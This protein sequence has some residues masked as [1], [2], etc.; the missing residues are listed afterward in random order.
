M[1]ALRPTGPDVEGITVN[2]LTTPL[3]GYQRAQR[4]RVQL[5]RL[6]AIHASVGTA[7]QSHPYPH[8]RNLT[9]S[10][11]VAR[12]AS[13][14]CRDDRGRPRIPYVSLACRRLALTVI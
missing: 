7:G 1:F 2:C 14:P 12:A 13:T 3:I 8:Q 5:S 10:R 9:R 6:A 11:P 4:T